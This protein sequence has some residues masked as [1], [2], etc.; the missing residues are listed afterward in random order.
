MP[1]SLT[2]DQSKRTP[3]VVDYVRSLYDEEILDTD[4]AFGQLLRALEKRERW[5]NTVL[6]ITADHGEEFWDHGEFEHG[7]TL[8]SVVT[9]VPLIVSGPGFKGMGKKD[10]LVEHVDLFQGI[11]ALG[12]AP[13]PEDSHGVNLFELAKLDDPPERWSLSEE[14]TVRR[15]HGLCCHASVSPL[16]QS[17]QWGGGTLEH[18][19]QRR[20]R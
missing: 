9:Q 13:S 17:I 3:E 4:A 11:L 1:M 12:G 2:Q 18:D 5:D 8:R 14:Y 20:R 6:I 19:G 15:T 16:A 10:V 7:H